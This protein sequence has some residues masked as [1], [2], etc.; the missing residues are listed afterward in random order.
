VGSLIVRR[1]LVLAAV[2]ALAAVTAAP[3]LAAGSSL[4]VLSVDAAGSDVAVLVTPPA[5][6]GGHD[7]GSGAWTVTAGGEVVTEKVEQVSNA[8][9]EVVL[10]FDTSGS[11]L[12]VAMESAK[13]AAEA[14]VGTLPPSTRIALVSF[15]STSNV[16][17]PMT[18][19]R[20]ALI[21]AIRGLRAQGETALYDA[22]IA[23]AGQ[24][25]PSGSARRELVVLSDGGDTVSRADQ[26]AAIRSLADAK[27]RGYVASLVTD[28]SATA[29]LDDLARSTGGRVVGATDP[30]GIRSV[31]GDIG[32]AL[33]NQYR[34][35]FPKRGRGQ[36]SITIEVEADGVSAAVDRVIA[37]PAAASTA[38]PAATSAPY[39]VETGERAWMKFAGL[40]FFALGALALALHLFVPSRTRRVSS[41]WIS[42]HAS[43][44]HSDTS[45]QE[46][47]HRA[48]DLAERSLQRRGWAARL[49]VALERAGVPLRPGEFALAVIAASAG[50]WF[51]GTVLFGPVLGILLAVVTAFAART[52]LR[53]KVK[54]RT[55]RFEG[56]LGETLQLLSGSLRSGYGLSQA[57]DAVAKNSESPT[58][59]EFNRLTMETR[60][61]RS[62]PEALTA[63]AARVGSEDFDWVVEAISI[64]REVGG[65]LTEL[66]DRAATTIRERENVRRQVKSLSAEGRLSAYVLGGIPVGLF[67]YMQI[68]N[69]DYVGELTSS[70]PGWIMLGVAITMMTLGSLWMRKLVQVKF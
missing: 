15:S 22:V 50:A 62:L 61:G 9:L 1:L 48:A 17:V 57:L 69:P 52:F 51:V 8:A 32:A 60:V 16:V 39:V 27:V 30:A 44:A 24:F 28:E 68:S 23:A 13:S 33:T 29:F 66:L 45:I 38:A 63:V 40:A 5:S 36:M 59:E 37:L 43:K 54:R 20:V 19:D 49:D 11:M 65:D 58:A 56:Q 35:S 12:G 2:S 41:R 31:F 25:S 21:D 3:A 70:G 6:L 55:S 42:E 7:L 4:D 26:A 14:F 10:A 67:L 34:L 64:N 18:T 46:L 47:T 53:M